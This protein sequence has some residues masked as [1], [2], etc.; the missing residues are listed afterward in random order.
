LFP[1]RDKDI[2]AA[3][4][5]EDAVVYHIDAFREILPGEH[6][7]ALD[8][9]LRSVSAGRRAENIPHLGFALVSLIIPAIHMRRF[10]PFGIENDMMDFPLSPNWKDILMDVIDRGTTN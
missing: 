10:I 4:K 1:K 9:I 5:V 8:N 3:F 7:A 2:Q 6:K